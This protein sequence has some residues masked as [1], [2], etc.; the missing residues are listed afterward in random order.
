MSGAWLSSISTKLQRF[1]WLLWLA[2]IALLAVGFDFKT[3]A[4]QF[5]TIKADNARQDSILVELGR[6]IRAMAI[7]E[8]LDRPQRETQLMGLPCGR[9]LK[10]QTFTSP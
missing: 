5:R 1:Q 6:Y 9:L 8:C 10:P 4:A 3:P 7:A 2:L